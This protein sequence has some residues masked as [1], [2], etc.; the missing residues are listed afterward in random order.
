MSKDADAPE[1]EAPAGGL[2]RDLRH[3]LAAQFVVPARVNRLLTE[4]E[5]WIAELPTPYREITTAFTANIR[6][7]LWTVTIPYSLARASALDRHYQRIS[8][9]E[10][11]G[12]L[13]LDATENETEADLRA[14]R[15]REAHDK[16][17]LGVE[18]FL[19]SKEGKEALTRDTCHFLLRAVASEPFALAAQELLLQGVVLCWGAF[20]VLGRDVFV[21]VLNQDPTLVDRLTSHPTAKRRFELAR[22]PLETLVSHGFNLSD[23]MGTLLAEQQ[24]LSDLNS[25]KAVFEALYPD[26]AALRHSIGGEDMRILA[27]RRNLIVHRRGIIDEAFA[28]SVGSAERPGDRLVVSPESLER[29]IGSV[30]DSATEL[31]KVM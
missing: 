17:R 1:P 27:L 3:R 12:S 9:A 20:E 2:L 31:L 11:I 16:T 24:D 28:R 19:A 18:A 13:M 6:G 29:H 30:I 15:E 10:H 7:L 26:A 14:R 4:F 5:T 21:A 22:L 23:R 25:L 8:T